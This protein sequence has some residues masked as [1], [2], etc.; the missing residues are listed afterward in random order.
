MPYTPTV[1]EDAPSTD[2]PLSATNLNHLETGVDDATTTADAAAAAAT[3]L[4]GR[5]DTVEAALPGKADDADV[6]AEATA[7]AAADTALDGRL[8]TV[9]ARAVVLVLDAADP[10]PGGTPAGTVILRRP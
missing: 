7:R 3:A 5:L 8:D 10:V 1:W 2:T 4:D 9:E 6:T